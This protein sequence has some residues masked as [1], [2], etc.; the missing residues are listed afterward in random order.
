MKW[1]EMITVRSGRRNADIITSTLQ[2]LL[3]DMVRKDEHERLRI[4]NRQGIDTDFCIIL[5]HT[6]RKTTSNGSRLGLR[7]TAALSELGQVHH[8]IW[9]EMNKP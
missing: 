9:R 5:F 3:N 8:V 1:I 6:G 7:L 4:Y 2:D